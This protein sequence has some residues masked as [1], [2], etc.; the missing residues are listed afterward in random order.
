MHSEVFLLLI[1]YPINKFQLRNEAGTSHFDGGSRLSLRGI[2]KNIQLEKNTIKGGVP[3]ISGSFTQR[4][5][6]YHG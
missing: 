2:F 6:D 4:N 5:I 1:I 3:R